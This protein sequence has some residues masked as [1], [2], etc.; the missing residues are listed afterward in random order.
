MTV[1]REKPATRRTLSRLLL[2]KNKPVSRG[3][4]R[5]SQSFVLF[6]FANRK[7]S[8][9]TGTEVLSEDTNP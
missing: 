2:S 1:W 7:D 6:P 9:V 4:C 8:D 5:V 3:I